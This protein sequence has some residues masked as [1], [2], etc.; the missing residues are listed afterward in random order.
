MALAVMQ[1]QNNCGTWRNIRVPAVAVVMTLKM[2]GCKATS[3]DCWYTERDAKLD[4]H[5]MGPAALKR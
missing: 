4:L 5:G 2:F 3:W 1:A